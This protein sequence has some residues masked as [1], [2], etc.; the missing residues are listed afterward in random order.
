MVK[1]I[2]KGILVFTIAILMFVIC[3][4]MPTVAYA[5]SYGSVEYE[6]LWYSKADFLDIKAAKGVVASWDRSVLDSIG[7]IYI[8][9][10]DTGITTAHEIFADTIARNS[11]D[12]PL[13]YNAYAAVSKTGSTTDITDTSSCHGTQ[14]AGIIAMLIKEFGLE[15]NIKI[16]PIKANTSTNDSFAID[17][18]IKAIQWAT[19]EDINVDVI[20]MS[21]GILEKDAPEWATNKTLQYAINEAAKSAVIV[22]AAGNDGKESDS[23][24]NTYYP[25]ALDGVVSV[26]GYGKDA[27][28]Y[29]TSNYGSAYDIVAPGEAIYTAGNYIKGSKVSTYLSDSK[30]TS[31]AAPFVSF[32]AALLKLRLLYEGAQ[33]SALNGNNL[34]RVI[35]KL[36]GPTITKGGY[37][38]TTLNLNSLLTQETT[39]TDYLNP[40]DIYLTYDTTYY[41][42]EI[43]SIYMKA[44]EIKP[45]TFNANIVPYGETNPDL[46]EVVEW[47]VQENLLQEIL[48]G[49]GTSITYAPSKGGKY[50]LIV[51][52]KYDQTTYSDSVSWGI[53]FLPFFISDARVTYK[54]YA[55]DDV[56]VAPTGGTTYTYD[57]TKLSL[58]G[59]QYVDTSVGIK[60][61]VNDQYAA[62]GEVFNF[63]V[64]KKG[65][66]TVTAVFGDQQIA[67]S[68]AFVFE[69]RPSIEKP[70]YLAILCVGCVVVIAAIAIISVVILKKNKKKKILSSSLMN[71]EYKA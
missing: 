50:K 46:N 9:V 58:T 29:S 71:E 40:T 45:I 34:S 64:G 68:N 25:A 39:I 51:K 38:F 24:A 49:T 5:S 56:D 28:I 37:H 67:G 63:K 22:S 7:T 70:L 6:N 1:R 31:M 59:I 43:D 60:W 44:D 42:D 32:A 11:S 23:Q 10:I 53:D 41:D 33:E 69:V 16:Y 52:L 19:S 18:A 27:K 12:V 17:T 61:Y 2:G 66:Y 35:T 4:S 30:G 55:M 48:I 14:V 54:D 15:K 21:F 62:D 36:E 47:Y 26:M 65:T 13:G 57:T 3:F 20:N 8:G